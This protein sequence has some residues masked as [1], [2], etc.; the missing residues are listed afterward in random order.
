MKCVKLLDPFAKGT[1]ILIGLASSSDLLASAEPHLQDHS[2]HR[3]SNER[4]RHRVRLA[5]R[6]LPDVRH[7]LD[8]LVICD[9]SFLVGFRSEHDVDPEGRGEYGAVRDGLW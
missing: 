9:K 6:L 3:A 2:G 8:L 1:R 7:F 5:A 4:H